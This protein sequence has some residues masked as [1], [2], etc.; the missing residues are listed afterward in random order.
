MPDSPTLVS[1][2]DEPRLRRLHLLLW[3]WAAIW[4]VPF[5][6]V[7]SVS[8]HFFPL[9]SRLLLGNAPGDGLDLY[10][11]HPQLQFGPVT[12]IAATPLVELPYR[13]GELVALLALAAVGPVLLLSLRRLMP[14]PHRDRRLLLAGLAVVP[15]WDEVAVHFGH[16][17]DV[18][19]LGFGVAALHAVAGRRPLLAAVLLAAA[20]DAKPWAVGFVALLLVFRGRVLLRAVGVWAAGVVAAWLPFLLDAPA[21]A[22]RLGHFT[23]PVAPS[24]A[25]HVFGVTATRT[26]P[27]DRPAQLLLGIGLGALAV[28]RGHWPAVLLMVVA[29]RLVLDPATYP[30]YTSGAVLAAA[31]V[32]LLLTTTTTPVLTLVSAATLY[33]VRFAPLPGLLTQPGL[34]WL[35][36]GFAAAAVAVV[37]LVLRPGHRRTHDP[38]G[39]RGLD[40]TGAE[41]A[42][43]SAA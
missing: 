23:I 43:A 29:A 10:A 14:G 19:A 25:L 20:A 38:G 11:A 40:G 34:A 2:A 9:G 1:P 8:W 18:L 26:P 6:A 7:A 37:L 5:F 32:D 17:D 27:W 21:T 28:R 16:L 4:V 24:S 15:V 36:I 41:L 13:L 35:R 42:P 31:V 33:A 39:T 30:Y 3:A 12:L 22:A